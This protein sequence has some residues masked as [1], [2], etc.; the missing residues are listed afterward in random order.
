MANPL[1]LSSNLIKDAEKQIKQSF[2][3]VP[4]QIEFWASIG[5][6]VESSMTPADVAALA[7]GEI[8]IQILR[9]KSEPVDFEG[10]FTRIEADRAANT[11][12]PKVLTGDVWYEE[13]K[14]HPEMLVRVSTSG[15][16]DVGIFKNG[17]FQVAKRLKKTQSK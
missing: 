11:L 16:R 14:E 1:R 9:K 3:S 17:K 15:K 10:V 8:E 5:K 7:N 12:V 2:R 6:E 4:K 13:S